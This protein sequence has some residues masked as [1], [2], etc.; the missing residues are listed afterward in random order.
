MKKLLLVILSVIACLCLAVGFVGCGGNGNEDKGSQDHVHTYST[1]WKSD[2]TYHWHKATCEHV[3]EVS[4]KAEHTIV[5]GECTVC[6]RAFAIIDVE[7]VIKGFI[8]NAYTANVNIDDKTVEVSESLKDLFIKVRMG[9]EKA[10]VDKTGIYFTEEEDFHYA[11]IKAV[12][13][14]I[15]FNITHMPL[16]VVIEQISEYL[17]EGWTFDD[18]VA[19]VWNG[20]E[21]KFDEDKAISLLE[22]FLFNEGIT[23]AQVKL[24][25]QDGIT[26]E[27]IQ[28]AIKPEII[29]LINNALPEGMT[30]EN[31]MPM[32]TN[33]TPA[34][35]QA[36][37]DALCAGELNAEL[38]NAILPEG[39]TVEM[40][41][42]YLSYIFTEQEITVEKVLEK[43]N[44]IVKVI[45]SIDFEKIAYE[46]EQ[47][48][49]KAFN[50]VVKTIFVQEKVD[51]GV[52]YTV[53]YGIIKE[54]NDYLNDTKLEAIINTV[55]GENFVDNTAEYLVY[56]LDSKLSDLKPLLEGYIGI[57]LEE[58][59]NKI[60]EYAEEYAPIINKIVA[61]MNSVYTKNE[62]SVVEYDEEYEPIVNND[63]AEINS[64]DEIDEDSFDVLPYIKMATAMVRYYLADENF[65]AKTLGETIEMFA[66]Q[67]GI[68]TDAIKGYITMAVNYLEAN[69]VY[70]VLES[71]DAINKQEFY[72]QVNGVA[73]ML[74][75]NFP[76]YFVINA[77][78]ELAELSVQATIFGEDDD[79]DKNISVLLKKGDFVGEI[80]TA[81]EKAEMAS[82]A[83]LYTLDDFN[84]YEYET[85]YEKVSVEF[86][87]EDNTITRTVIDKGSV[88]V[89][90]YYIL[91][92]DLSDNAISVKSNGQVRYEISAIMENIYNFDWDGDGE[93]ED[94][95]YYSIS[96]YV[97]IIFS[98][99]GAWLYE[100]VDFMDPAYESTND[101]DVA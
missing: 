64:N 35:V 9:E 46:I 45:N 77:D 93:Y 89:I 96:T 15:V 81:E 66:G 73:D 70:D 51:G 62:S 43:V 6:G 16:D 63:V 29:A 99:D 57:T 47:A 30:L 54:A 84:D 49:I 98:E 87:S 69:T 12:A 17:P 23:V 94:M 11:S 75:A 80:F 3:D 5:D 28:T 76:V 71:A 95:D 61:A 18:L 55:L 65:M 53:N 60:D 38:I 72:A 78:G 41:N 14:E 101:Y 26:Y 22:D 90:T 1:E 52:K 100:D 42:T 59:L 44:A 67:Q 20:E 7:K 58:V 37:F 82:A 21:F 86:N 2:K 91:D 25:A 36:I 24:M 79:D 31:I 88:D 56:L 97:S 92:T 48:E 34:K 33:I 40:F 13:D 27:D 68:T 19:I 10:L 74:A 32:L 50:K 83:A 8:N 39:M 85:E 4:G